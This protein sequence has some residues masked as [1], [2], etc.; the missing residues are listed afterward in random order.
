MVLGEEIAH[1]NPLPHIHNINEV[2]TNFRS[3]I[4]QGEA[5]IPGY[6]LFDHPPLPTRGA[7]IFEL[8]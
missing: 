2:F 6:F 5:P 3:P 4:I 8:L 1:K 7:A